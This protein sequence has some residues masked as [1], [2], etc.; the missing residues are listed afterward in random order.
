MVGEIHGVSDRVRRRAQTLVPDVKTSAGVVP[1]GRGYGGR[2]GGWSAPYINYGGYRIP[3]YA[4]FAF[5]QV[6]YGPAIE[7]QRQLASEDLEA[8]MQQASQIMN[9]ISS[10]LEQMRQTLTE[11]YNMPF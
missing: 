10:E 9:E 5:R 4:P 8:G 11:R 2:Y 1:V 7:Q 6:D 3:T